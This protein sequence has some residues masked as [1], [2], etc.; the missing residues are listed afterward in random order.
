MGDYP[1][2][3]LIDYEIERGPVNIKRYNAKREITVE[4]GLNNPKEAVPP[5]LA[6]IKENIIDV[7]SPMVV[8][9][10]FV[11]KLPPLYEGTR[12]EAHL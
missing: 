11:K 8:M 7:A 9:D 1:V 6:K 3:E 4:A 10:R 2:S 12:Q 5:I